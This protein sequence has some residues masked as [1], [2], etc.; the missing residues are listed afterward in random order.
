MERRTG[1][2][3][4]VK[5]QSMP[6]SLMY[7]CL[8]RPNRQTAVIPDSSHAVPVIAQTVRVTLTG[9]GVCSVYSLANLNWL[10][11]QACSVDKAADSMCVLFVE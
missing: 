9:W 11:R 6:V 10:Q 1:S 7:L 2:C 4:G 3:D 5:L 8:V